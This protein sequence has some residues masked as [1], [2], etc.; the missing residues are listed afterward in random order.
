M[1]R[2]ATVAGRSASVQA[3]ISNFTAVSPTIASFS[4]KIVGGDVFNKKPHR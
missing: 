2:I 4:G 1:F 3:L